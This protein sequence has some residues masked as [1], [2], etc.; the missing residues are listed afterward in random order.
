[1]DMD[2]GPSRN[3]V[4]ANSRNTKRGQELTDVV[5]FLRRNIWITVSLAV[6]SGGA[7]AAWSIM[8]PRQYKASSV[9]RISDERSAI[10]G[11]I[12]D[13][14]RLESAALAKV[15]DPIQSQI[16]ILRSRALLG[17]VVDSAELRVVTRRFPADALS[18]VT[19]AA[20]ARVDTIDV[21]FSGSGFSVTSRSGRLE[22]SYGALVRLPGLS[23]AI[24][25]NPGVP[26]G[27]I[28][29]LHR[30]EAVDQLVGRMRTR[31]R[32]K[33]DII[34][35]EYTNESPYIAERV[36]N[37]IARR[38]ARN[39]VEIAQQRSMR[40]RL[41]IEEQMGQTDSLLAIAV[42]EL[43]E[44]RQSEQVFNTRDRFTQ[45]Q[46]G[47][48]NL[49]LRQEELVAERT[50]YQSLLRSLQGRGEG[51]GL[52]AMLSSPSFASN[53]VISELTSQ[54]LRHEAARDSLLSGEYRV[55]AT[56]PQ[57]QRLNTLI[58][59]T[60]G[61][62]LD[63]ARTHIMA[64]DARISSMNERI[65]D[66]NLQMQ[67]LPEVEARERQLVQEA[68]TLRRMREQLQEE[69]Q[70]AR[71]AEAAEAGNVQILDEASFPR[72]PVPAQKPLK[73]AVGILFGLVMGLLLS[74]TR[75]RLSPRIF[76]RDEVLDSV[77]VTALAVVPPLH[78]AHARGWRKR[79]AAGL[80]GADP[81]AV[82]GRVTPSSEAYRALRT[83][84][85]FAKHGE[86]RTLLVTSAEPSEGKSTTISNLAAVYAR[87]GQRVLLIDCDL[88]KPRLHQVFGVDRGKG[89]AE[90]LTGQV[91]I[92]DVLHNPMENLYLMTAGE[93]P[94][95]PADLLDSPLTQ[96]A[97]REASSHFDMLLVD[98]PPVLAAPDAPILG[99]YVD[100]V[101]M[102]LRAGRTPERAARSAADQI[103][104][105]GGYLIGAVLND[106]DNKVP[107]HGGGYY[108]YG[109]YAY[110]KK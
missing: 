5:A 34:A 71:I 72:R 22:A 38:F 68:E 44:F 36:A 20:E 86:L 52:R 109:Y 37:T 66:N 28:V 69:H 83:N 65:A 93:L 45:Q 89:V 16:Q 84:L 105:V 73:I 33:A 74:L 110:G 85:P 35:I 31:T 81:L 17:S 57:L 62:L 58:A 12:S 9:V 2:Q 94:A 77:G 41:F 75:E 42:M 54:L 32:D 60:E 14:G 27:Q 90:W 76:S 24:D 55:A 49:E 4:R 13:I 103:E 108:S 88:R 87:Q 15:L 95:N 7:A 1:M 63:A 78:A 70:R 19:L 99:R 11:G 51:R 25:T 100:G 61:K 8:Q 96:A 59:T 91:K 102:V 82:S 107:Q 53:P 26:E 18:K 104:S 50:V 67:T 48:V 56:D 106:P 23:F 39:G 46:T 79:K 21:R 97:L 80:N 40:R 30:E 29:I 10:A 101:L 6:I 3:R 43:N 64:L 47:V 98:T 92:G